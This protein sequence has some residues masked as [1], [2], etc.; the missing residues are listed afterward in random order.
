LT[1]ITL[2]VQSNDLTRKFSAMF[3]SLTEVT[4]ITPRCPSAVMMPIKVPTLI[5][6]RGIASR[7]T[8]EG[9]IWS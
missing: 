3:V 5:S 2:K 6:V 8:T 9:L 4:C 7:V 1:G